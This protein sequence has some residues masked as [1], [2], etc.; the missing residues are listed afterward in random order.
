M[1]VAAAA[2]IVGLFVTI[3]IGSH[4]A[5]L[6][7]FTGGLWD[8]GRAVLAHRD[9]YEPGFLARQA[10]IMHAGGVA[11]GVRGDDAFSTPLYPAPVNLAVVPLSL[12]PLWPAGSLYT[13]LSVVAMV[14]AMRVLGVR[15]WRCVGVALVSLPSLDGLLVGSIGPWLV[16][17]VSIAWRY[18]ER[19]WPC[20]LAVASVVTAKL[21]PWP[22]AIWLA[23]TRRYRALA[24]AVIVGVSA[25]AGAWLV[26]GLDSLASYPQMLANATALQESR[27]DTPA[28]VLIAVGASPVLARVA[29]ALIAASLLGLAWTMAR[30]RADSARAFSLTIIAG[31]VSSPIVWSH[32]MVLLLVPIA[33]MSPQI[34]AIWVLP[35]LSP[36]LIVVA[37]AIPMG[38][39]LTAVTPWVL[40]EGLV[41]AAVCRPRSAT[42][43]WRAMTSPPGGALRAS[44]PQL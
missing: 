13:I 21:F 23:A 8:A 25:T 44:P 12:L 33:L 9:P 22:L 15:D 26:I 5:V 34:S 31:L 38:A 14:L 19:V 39:A 37:D 3:V 6:I 1:S 27:S 36:L 40:L 32:Y 11:E 18:R 4:G 7:D 41:T 24:L 2:G 28:A 10:A 35:L 16:L 29:G 30:R 43:P 17:G 42:V 20:A